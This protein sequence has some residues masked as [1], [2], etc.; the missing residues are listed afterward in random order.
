M[1]KRKSFVF[2]MVTAAV[3]TVS[4]GN[5]SA[6]VGKKVSVTSGYSF[7]IPASPTYSDGMTIGVPSSYRSKSNFLQ[8]T[9]TYQS[10]CGGGDNMRT[11]VD[12]GGVE[13]VSVP[14]AAEA[15]DEDASNQMVTKVYYLLPESQ[16]GSPVPEGSMVTLKLT[17]QLGTGCT[18]YNGTMVVEALK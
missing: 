18:A 15:F 4:A 5:A 8:A 17:S 12:V 16:G 1:G 14:A 2:F 10:S 6:Q 7:S 13:M 3:V 11:K 9:V